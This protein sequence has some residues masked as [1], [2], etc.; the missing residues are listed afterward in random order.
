M[1][2]IV[3]V[4]RSIRGLAIIPVVAWLLA[5]SLVVQMPPLHSSG[6]QP[7]ITPQWMK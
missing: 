4:H 6:G 5:T 3:L 1:P 2:S 7:C